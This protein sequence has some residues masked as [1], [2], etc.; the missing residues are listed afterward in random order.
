ML[1][2][3][4]QKS[5]LFCGP[6]RN[7][8]AEVGRF[9]ALA[10]N[11]DT[12]AK[13]AGMTGDAD[14]VDDL[15]GSRAEV[16]GSGPAGTGSAKPSPPAATVARPW[17]GASGRSRP[18]N[19]M[20]SRNGKHAGPAPPRLLRPAG[21]HGKG[22]TW[23]TWP[24]GSARSCGGRIESESRSCPARPAGRRKATPERCSEDSL[25]CS[26][27]VHSFLVGRGTR[28]ISKRSSPL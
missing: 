28:R 15:V 9:D 18:R 4:G 26:F 21:A 24:L 3:N 2:P 27:P 19:A 20:P 17:P 22:A 5:A 16:T 10:I 1:A 25:R 11:L 13:R 23:R 12:N 6:T 7:H 8:P 14:F